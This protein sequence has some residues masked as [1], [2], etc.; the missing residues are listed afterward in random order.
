M[1]IIA[2]ASHPTVVPWLQTY[3]SVINSVYFSCYFEH[4]VH[5][6]LK[7]KFCSG[8]SSAPTA[9]S[10]SEVSSVLVQ[11]L[12]CWLPYQSRPG[13]AKNKNNLHPTQAASQNW[14]VLPVITGIQ[15][16]PSGNAP[17]YTGSWLTPF[18]GDRSQQVTQAA[19]VS[20][21]KQKAPDPVL[22][23]LP[24]LRIAV[25]EKTNFPCISP[26]CLIE[27]PSAPLKSCK[28]GLHS[29]CW[30]AQISDKVS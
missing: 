1:L 28:S 23:C 30:L 27:I 17:W 3:V 22:S 20:P 16:L 10:Q 4:E 24:H 21:Q 12:I 25:L 29:R 13:T 6:M 14:L 18:S 19:K 15:S 26:F 5:W 11:R 2:F 9:S 8:A 7:K